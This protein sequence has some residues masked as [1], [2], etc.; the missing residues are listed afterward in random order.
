MIGYEMV[1]EDGYIFILGVLLY[2]KV[3]GMFGMDI[4]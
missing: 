3:V 2:V 1:I 4:F